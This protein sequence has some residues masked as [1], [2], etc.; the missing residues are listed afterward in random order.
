MN[1]IRLDEI[2]LVRAV[3]AR[4]TDIH[5]DPEL[6]GYSVRMRIDG[7]LRLW[8]KFNREDGI[9]LLNQIKADV[10]IDMGTVFYPVSVRRKIKI[11]ERLLDLRV[12]LVP[13]ASGPKLS[14]RLLDTDNVRQK[15]STLG[16]GKKPSEQLERWLAELNGVFLVTGPTGSGKTST[17]YALLDDLVLEERHVVTI[18]D[19][20]EYEM[21]GINQIE[22]NLQH[23]LTFAKGVKTSLRMD[24]DC[25]MV[26][27]IRE[28]ETARQALNAAVMGHVVM[29]TMHSRDAVSI[30]T[31]LRNFGLENHQIAAALGVIVNQRL[32]GKIC[33][34]CAK[35][36]EATDLETSFFESRKL[37]PPAKV[38]AASGCDECDDTGVHGRTGVFE[39]WNLDRSDYQMILDGEDEENIR[40]K[41]AKESHRSL[42]HDALIKV[43]KGIISV[44][45]VMQMGLSLPWNNR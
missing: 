40:E 41:L 43:E 37:Q 11:E 44:T 15:L 32:V 26:G 17:A 12:S 5:I 13:C 2:L 39:V 36:R 9:R 4:A 27:E 10:G 21:D 3:N 23:G 30:I 19:P 24:P 14:I 31:Q 1:E 6:E 20:V 7:R 34:N 29:A 18:E 22:V 25:L 16:L 33:Q 28:P 8:Q 38:Y 45:E 42:L 35:E